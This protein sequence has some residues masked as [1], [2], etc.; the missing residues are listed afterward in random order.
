MIAILKILRAHQTCVLYIFRKIHT[1][2][3][4]K[5]LKFIHDFISKTKQKFQIINISGNKVYGFRTT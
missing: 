1:E 2:N 5:I 4:I 3:E